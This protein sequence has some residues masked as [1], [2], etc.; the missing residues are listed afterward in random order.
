MENKTVPQKT[1]S[2]KKSLPEGRLERNIKNIAKMIAS[3]SVGWSKLSSL[4][5][6]RM[7]AEV[8]GANSYVPNH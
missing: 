1:K 3:G 5:Y 4:P 6:R 8:Q 7:V 2:K